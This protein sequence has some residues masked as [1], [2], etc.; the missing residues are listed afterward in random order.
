MLHCTEIFKNDNNQDLRQALY[1]ALHTFQEYLIIYEGQYSIGVRK[2]EETL[3][4]IID[5]HKPNIPEHIKIQRNKKRTRLY[6]SLLTGI[7]VKL[8]ECA[9]LENEEEVHMI[10][11]RIDMKVQTET[12][13]LLSGLQSNS[14]KVTSSSFNMKTKTLMKRS[15]E[16]KTEGEL[17]TV[18]RVKDIE[19]LTEVTPI[20]FVADFICFELLRHF[21]RK[22]KVQQ[23]IKFHS[24]EALD[25]FPLKNKVAFIG[26]NYFSD[27][28]F[29]PTNDG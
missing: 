24:E 11:D 9:I 15:C 14:K 20:S 5:Q 26:D 2:S 18:S 23:P 27:L 22:M 8:E 19:Y 6:I 16:I 3:T 17:T 21:R 29:D 1:S 13:Q 25:G 28:V 12:N 4:K 7:I 10:S